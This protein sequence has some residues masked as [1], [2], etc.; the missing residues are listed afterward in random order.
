MP[1]CQD[2]AGRRSR[3]RARAG[4]Y[5]GSR[6]ADFSHNI[7]E[8]RF[9]CKLHK[10]HYIFLC[11]IAV[12]TYNA[13]YYKIGENQTRE[14]AQG[15]TKADVIV[16]VNNTY[17]AWEKGLLTWSEYRERVWEIL[18]ESRI[19]EGDFITTIMKKMEG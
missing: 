16:L 11:N 1:G 10:T 2:H 12:L 4:G 17:K 5:I 15:M 18:I 7:E 19:T 3:T 14:E 13:L 9:M 6:E 8:T